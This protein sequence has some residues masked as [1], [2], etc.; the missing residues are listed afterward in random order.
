MKRRLITII[1]IYG[2]FLTSCQQEILPITTNSSEAR[3]LYLQGR[4][5]SERL[6]FAESFSYFEKAVSLDTNFALA[7]L[8]LA[9]AA[10]NPVDRFA[11]L[12][13]AKS[14]ID[15]VSEGEQLLIL[16]TEAGF[17]GFAGKQREYYIKLVEAYPKDARVHN[18]LGIHYFGNQEYDLAIKQ[19][20]VASQLDPDFS[21]PYNQLG[22]CYRFK[23]EY[24]K[25]ERAF[26][27]Y[28]DLIPDDPNPYDSYAELLLQMGEYEVSIE[29]YEKA[30][31]LNSDFTFAY[32]GIATNLILRDEHNQAIKKL[33]ELYL[34][35]DDIGTKRR[36]LG[37][38]AIIYI[39][40]G[41]TTPAIK[42]IQKRYAL[43]E[44]NKD[45]VSM[46]G[47]KNFLG[48][49][50]FQD[51]D[52]TSAE[53]SWLEA[54]NLIQNSNQPDD[55]KN[56]FRR[57]ECY[58]H[59]RLAVAR[60]NISEAWENQKRYYD[61]ASKAENFFQIRASHELSGMIY[62]K[63]GKYDK[64]I[65]EFEQTD[66]QNPQNLF[67]LGLAYEAGADTV[68]AIDYYRRAAYA[69]ALSSLNYAFVR[70][71]ALKKYNMLKR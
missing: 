13:K 61:A 20:K 48:T 11:F 68:S 39:D 36:A 42:I 26:K 57:I 30:L 70:K 27:K 3:D 23:G 44:S 41:K 34:L 64:A 32:F 37:G 43:S 10:N 14:K 60:N 63:E 22:Y 58:N 5:L 49:V 8:S 71:D 33:K 24:E 55:I 56:I 15:L 4:N 62:Y 7:Y 16:G 25:A 67:R 17:V 45:T 21:Q 69:N 65:A 47:D 53:N 40:E 29:M 28:I 51:G 9:F 1:F 31:E 50:F 52:L 6:R 18:I 66:Q 59:T 46:S 2:L 35:R 54:M 12:D 19:Y 38:M